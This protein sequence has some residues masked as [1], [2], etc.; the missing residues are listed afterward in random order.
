MNT[1]GNNIRRLREA[2]D[3]TQA[4]LA[5][6]MGTTNVTISRWESG[7]RVFSSSILRKL[8]EVFKVSPQEILGDGA[9]PATAQKPGR[10]SKKT[11]FNEMPDIPG[12]DFKQNQLPPA[13]KSIPFLGFG[14][15]DKELLFDTTVLDRI[16]DSP[17]EALRVIEISDDTMAPSL[18]P[19]DFVLVDTTFAKIQADGLFAIRFKE[20][21]FPVIR[22]VS[23]NP[24]TGALT[25]AS[26]N[27]AYQDYEDVD[28]ANV[29]V[30][31]RVIWKSQRT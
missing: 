11:A 6:R 1:P 5:K 18:L 31:G 4:D 17:F 7:S 19:Q 23:V 26:D 3:W 2:R 20:G 9:Q 27:P 12:F 30:F 8:A 22:R 16:T 13:M 28:A 29:S 14:R 15:E 21:D 10:P 25:I 24:M